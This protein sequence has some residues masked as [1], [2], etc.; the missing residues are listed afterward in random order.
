MGFLRSLISFLTNMIWGIEIKS[1][2]LM[3]NILT[4]L[5]VGFKVHGNKAHFFFDLI[6]EIKFIHHVVMPEEI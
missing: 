3:K 2:T 6:D 5:Q 1:K 4:Q